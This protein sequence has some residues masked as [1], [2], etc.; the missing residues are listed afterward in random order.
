MRC[1]LWLCTEYSAVSPAA[2]SCH[3]FS[4]RR[5]LHARPA[6]IGEIGA[7]LAAVPAPDLLLYE[8]AF[9]HGMVG[10][11]IRDDSGCKSQ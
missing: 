10:I 2:E 1:T 6:A 9:P 11:L 5:N 3:L 8:S 7:L 4:L